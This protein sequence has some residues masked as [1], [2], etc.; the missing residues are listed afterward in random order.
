MRKSMQQATPENSARARA[1]R[2]IRTLEHA[3]RVPL[4]SIPTR[5][6]TDTLL[7]CDPVHF[8]VKDVK[9]PFMEGHIGQVDRQTAREQWWELKRTFERLGYAVLVVPGVENLEDMVFTANQ[10]LV[11]EDEQGQPYIVLSRM[12]HTSRQREVPHFRQWFGARGYRILELP[13]QPGADACYFE[14]QGDAIW[15]PGRRLLW[16]GY[17]QRTELE[18]YELLSGTLGVPVVVLRL[19]QDKFYHLDTAFCALSED[20]VMIYPPAFDQ[21]GVELVRYYFKQVVEVDEADA[22]NFACNAVALGGKVIL[23]KGSQ[24]TCRKLREIGF[25]P[26]EVD[27]GE[28]MKSGGSV[29]CLKMGIY[30]T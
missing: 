30:G 23:Q 15:H 20:A 25:D 14:G 4:D 28:F 21:T 18:A 6:E 29:F 16:G 17:G 24:Q 19:V 9:N 22:D 11:G 3:G 10:V 12:R 1:P 5:R 26:V 27:T 7:M 2:I 13:H 8:E